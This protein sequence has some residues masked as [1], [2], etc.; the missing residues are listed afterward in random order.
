MTP[1]HSGVSG[2]TDIAEYYLYFAPG[3]DSAH[4]GKE[5]PDANGEL[6]GRLMKAAKLQQDSKIV[7]RVNQKTWDSLKLSEDVLDF[8]YL[9]LIMH[10][11]KSDHGALYAL[12]RHIRNAIVHGY[13][14]IWKK[15]SGNFIYLMD[16]D[17]GKHKPTAKIVVTDKILA[18]WMNILK[19][20]SGENK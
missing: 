9:R 4:A 8:E 12:L 20:E 14:Y 16:I 18:S 19:T 11:C 1:F 6:F 2:F 13:I 5:I 10:Q 3:V 7:R 17:S 15:K